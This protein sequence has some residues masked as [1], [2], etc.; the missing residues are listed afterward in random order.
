[1]SINEPEEL[2]GMGAG[3]HV[4]HQMLE[5][6]NYNRRTLMITKSA[7]MLLTAA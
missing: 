6:G 5:A 7:Q 4:V 2:A 3:G 1:M